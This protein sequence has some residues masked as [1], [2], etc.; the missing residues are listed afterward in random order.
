MPSQ[1]HHTQRAMPGTAISAAPNENGPAY[2]Q[3]KNF[4]RTLNEGKKGKTGS[5]VRSRRLEARSG[6]GKRARADACGFGAAPRVTARWGKKRRQYP[7]PF[8]YIAF[9][10]IAVFALRK[11]REAHYIHDYN[12]MKANCRWPP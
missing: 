12:A 3:E 4:P 10:I 6:N 2:S 9:S 11:V 5:A 7:V 8:L 1:L